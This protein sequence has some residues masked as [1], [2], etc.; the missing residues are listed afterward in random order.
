[1]HVMTRYDHQSDTFVDQHGK[2]YEQST[3]NIACVDGEIT[4]YCWQNGK[5][6][7]SIALHETAQDAA[8]T[9]IL[10]DMCE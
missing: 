2:H 4:Q 6:Y 9:A 8:M 5:W 10:N 1:M 3:L 7:S